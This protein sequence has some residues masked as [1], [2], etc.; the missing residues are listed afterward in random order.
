MPFYSQ[1]LQ[2]QELRLNL[3][4]ELSSIRP[5]FSINGPKIAI[6]LW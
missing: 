2:G 5:E 3:F 6:T 1:L 4:F